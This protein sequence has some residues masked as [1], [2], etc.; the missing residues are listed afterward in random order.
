MAIVA[1]AA[2]CADRYGDRVYAIYKPVNPGGWQRDS[3]VDFDMAIDVDS[4]NFVAGR[5]DMVLSV[6]HNVAYPYSD[7]WVVVETSG[8]HQDIR[9]DTV[10][11]QFADSSG[12]WLGEGA[13]SLRI[14]N[15]TVARDI[16]VDQSWQV[17]VTQV[18][19][20]DAIKN[21]TD[22]GV[23]LLRRNTN[24]NTYER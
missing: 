20:D 5:Y 17:R 6:R 16:L 7:L 10:R 1:A 19:T 4:V 14:V 24:F 11:M 3:G 2:G 21:I 9:T 13:R 23:I 8:M 18:M 15:D 12:R 22:V